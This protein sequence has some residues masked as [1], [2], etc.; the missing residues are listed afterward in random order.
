MQ[1]FPAVAETF[2][3]TRETLVGRA[4]M[5][6]LRRVTAADGAATEAGLRA[7]AE[8]FEEREVLVQEVGRGNV[9]RKNN[10]RIFII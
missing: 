7:A 8:A 10:P 2:E 5:Q 6:R 9:G 1:G 3:R 4:C